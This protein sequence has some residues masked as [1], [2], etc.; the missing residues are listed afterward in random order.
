MGIRAQNF[1]VDEAIGRDIEGVRSLMENEIF[2]HL[3][4]YICKHLCKYKVLI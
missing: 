3:H 1:E 2:L 4:L